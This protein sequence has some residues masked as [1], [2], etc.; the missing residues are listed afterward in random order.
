MSH[1]SENFT[2][3]VFYD[4]K[5]HFDKT[6]DYTYFFYQHYLLIS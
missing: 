2:T 5:L 6:N 3:P 1:V 4:K